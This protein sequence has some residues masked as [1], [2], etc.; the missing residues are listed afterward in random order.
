MAVSQFDPYRKDILLYKEAGMSAADMIRALEAD[1]GI[2]VKRSS[3]YLYCKTLFAQ[4]RAAPPQDLPEEALVDSVMQGA[5][6]EMI[7]RL[8]QLI[9][10]VQQV[11]QEGETRHAA[12]MDALQA[13]TLHDALDRH[14]RQFK[15]LFDL[16]RG[17]ALWKIWLRALFYT[18]AGW[19]VV[20][21]ALYAY[22]WGLSF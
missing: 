5:Q 19:G 11:G 22:F 13:F 8:A 7:D 12:V 17:T 3:F 15:A 20:L 4:E 9:E 14:S 6:G 2:E 1:H 10:A 21:A 16:L 18:G